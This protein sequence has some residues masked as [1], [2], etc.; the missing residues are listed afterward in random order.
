MIKNKV[1]T[2]WDYSWGRLVIS[3]VSAK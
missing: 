2:S 3:Q 1:Y